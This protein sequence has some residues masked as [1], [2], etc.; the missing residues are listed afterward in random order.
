M[1]HELRTPLNAIIGYSEMLEE[2]ALDAGQDD[3]IPDL[4]KIHSA[5]KHLLSLINDILDLSKIEAGKME[6]FVEPFEVRPTLDSVATTVRPLIEKNGN[7]LELQFDDG[8]GTMHSDL[9]RV[10]QVLLNLLSNASKFTENGTITLRAAREGERFVFSVSDTGIGMTPEQQ[11]KLFEA[12]SQ[13]DVS[14]AARYGGTGLGLAIS[15]RFCQMLGGD[16]SVHSEAGVGSIFTVTLPAVALQRAAAEPTPIESSVREVEKSTGVSGTVL[17]VDDDPSARVLMA[18]LLAREGFRVEEAADGP[19]A[20]ELA[21][22]LHPDLITLDVMMPGMDGW[23][24]LS[25]LKDAPETADIPVV[26]STIL[27]EKNMGFALGASAYLTKPIDRDRL[28]AVLRRYGG[29]RARRTVLVVEDD[30]GTRSLV[31]RTLEKQGWTVIE[32]EN[33]RVGL[34]RLEESRPALILLDLLMPEMDGFEFLEQLRELDSGE[35]IPVVVIT[36]KELTDN[37]RQRLNGGVERVVGK[38]NQSKDEFLSIVRDLV[39]AHDPAG[40]LRGQGS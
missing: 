23:S 33:G 24:V 12:F 11:G 14:T 27:D 31:R 30:E 26:M 16:I 13:A 18:R 1:S 38:G 17:V 7:R 4:Q 9:T 6:L 35:S 39:A 21:R 5:G 29:D 15:K 32:A 2:D 20:L 19:S 22:D 25:A 10:R 34:E 36:A 3:F 8:L 40:E 28:A 37:D